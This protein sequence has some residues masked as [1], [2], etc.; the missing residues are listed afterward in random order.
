MSNEIFEVDE[1]TMTQ[2]LIV[3]SHAG[4]EV[5]GLDT[6][7]LQQVFVTGGDDRTI[8]V[9]KVSSR[10]PVM[11]REIE[12]SV[13]CVAYNND[14]TQ[15][16][17]GL[18]NGKLVILSPKKLEEICTRHTRET[19]ITDVKFSADGRCVLFHRAPTPT[20]T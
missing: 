6:H 1:R 11:V 5:W 17:A 3:Q 2:R 4:A 19:V 12:E 14:G 16:A 18:T 10:K 9:F 13:R 15:I 8:R 20:R 7:P